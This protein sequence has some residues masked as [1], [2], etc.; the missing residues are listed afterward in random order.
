MM[1]INMAI[2]IASKIMRN[3]KKSSRSAK[4]IE[5]QITTR[6]GIEMNRIAKLA[7]AFL[8]SVLPVVDTRK[9]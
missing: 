4:L 6:T 3:L 5:A 9:Y 8:S 1:H 7:I 2:S